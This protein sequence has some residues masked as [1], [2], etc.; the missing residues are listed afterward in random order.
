MIN[1]TDKSKCSGCYACVDVCPEK[2]IAMHRDNEGFNYPLVDMDKCVRCEVCLSVC[3]VLCRYTVDSTPKAYAAYN[4]DDT[5]RQ[6]SSSGG[7]FTNL[8]LDVLEKNG[9]VF[10]ALFDDDFNVYHGHIEDKADL[11]KMRKSKYVQSEIGNSFNIAKEFLQAGRC[12]LFSGTPCQLAG[13]KLFLSKPYD[14][15][16]MVDIICHGVPSP[17][18]WSKYRALLSEK[19]QIDQI[20]FRDQ[21]KGWRDFA[22]R[23][24]FKRGR[25][26]IKVQDDDPYLF[27]FF[28]NIILRPACYDCTEKSLHRKA[29][30]TIADFW[31]IE[32]AH[33][34]FSDDIGISL[35]ITQGAKGEAALDAIRPDIEIIDSDIDMVPKYNTAATKS[36]SIPDNRDEFFE[37]LDEIDFKTLLATYCTEPFSI[38]M[39]KKTD[40]QIRKLKDMIKKIIRRK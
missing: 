11:Y 9:V 34:D 28:R 16:L 32:N 38:R 27:A 13:L 29:D 18:V 24:D 35:I 30:I 33:P 2:C 25:K 39:K 5:I 37:K 19:E 22:L 31:G 23:F 26:K 21:T 10:G 3:H 15:L 20:N 4:K 36:S 7:I 40:K 6:N 1:I 14:N 17:K 12:V 8:A